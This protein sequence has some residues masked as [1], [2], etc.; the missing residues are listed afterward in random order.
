M[1]KLRDMADELEEYAELEGTEY[2]RYLL[3][4]V[5]IAN[6]CEDSA[7]YVFTKQVESELKKTLAYIHKRC[8]VVESEFTPKPYKVRSLE[9]L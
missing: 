4:L 7:N 2:G 8:K 3:A 1:S 6:C 9:W 5:E